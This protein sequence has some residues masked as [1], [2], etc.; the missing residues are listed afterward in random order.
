MMGKSSVLLRYSVFLAALFLFVQLWAKDFWLEKP[1]TKWNKKETE[2]VLNNSPWADSMTFSE[3]APVIS[4]TTPRSATMGDTGERMDVYRIFRVRFLSAR[5]VRMALSRWNWIAKEGDKADGADEGNRKFVDTSFPNEI[6]L[7]LE[8]E[9]NARRSA[10]EVAKLLSSLTLARLKPGTYLQSPGGK[11]NYIMDYVPPSPDGLGAKLVFA[12]TMDGA[13]FIT[14]ESGTLRFV[15]EISDRYK[16]NLQ[17][18]LEKMSF[19]GK[20]EY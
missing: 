20:L 17:F 12:R 9:T 16:L 15:S 19:D 6:V 10:A 3:P 13:P 2:K 8:A 5:P 1:F 7:S 11:K 4:S 18:K 14:E